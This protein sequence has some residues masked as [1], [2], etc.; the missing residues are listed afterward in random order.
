MDLNLLLSAQSLTLAPQLQQSGSVNGLVVLK[1]VPARTYLRVTAEEWVILQLFT[2]PRTVPVAL[3]KAIQERTCIP[4]GVF[5][6]LVLKA[7]R[8]QILLEPGAPPEAVRAHD[9]TWAVRPRI[10]ARPLLALLLVG[11]VMALGFRPRLPSSFDDW[12]SGLAL[13]SAALSFGGFLAACMVRGAKGEVYRPGWRWLAAPPHFEVD[14]HDTL[15]LPAGDQVAI[16]MAVPAV[17]ATAAGIAAWHRPAWA[18]LPLLG[19]MASLRPVLGGRLAALIRVGLGRAPS[20]SEHNY[21]FPP[22]RRPASRARLLWRAI[23]ETTT[24]ARLGYGVLW[25]LAVLYWVA[26]LG[27]TPPWSLAFWEA[28][29][30]RIAQAIGASLFLLGVSYAAWEG[31]HLAREGARVRRAALRLWKRRWFGG[32]LAPVDESG[33]VKALAASPLF[34]TLQPPQRQEL[35]RSMSVRKLGPWRRIAENHGAPARVSVIISGKVSLR[36]ETS[37]GRT[38]HLQILSEGDVIG[39][40]DLAD[41]KVS[42]YR[43]RSMTPVTLLTVDRS[44]VEKLVVAKLPQST[45]ADALLK[46][47]FL[48]QIPLCRHWHLQAISRFARLSSITGYSMGDTILSEGQTVE[49]FFVIF[50]GDARV[51]RKERNLAVIHAG[52]FFGEI[53]L[54]Q[55]SSPN[56]TVVANDGTRCLR[57]PRIELLR[58]VTHN[59][60]VALEIERVSSKRLGRPLFP[61]RSGDFRTN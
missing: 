17:L 61:L 30:I 2:T 56:A 58:F 42:S 57:I 12:A 36:R 1:N 41:P 45:L 53:G 51:S 24:W 39:L 9:W 11:I 32:D 35:A 14:L 26:R 54:M 52:E 19:L 46:L 8:A 28:N 50:Q 27:D 40:H 7:F 6:E 59:Y 10:L 44:L 47:P 49:D 34:S 22:N 37:S 31:Y 18:F 3:G 4:L 48:R 15:M 43:E 29:G 25:T 23:G 5:Y 38:E 20:D 16:A 33:R 55:N 13:L 21:L 60:A